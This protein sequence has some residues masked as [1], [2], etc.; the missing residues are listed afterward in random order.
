MV[1]RL[2]RLSGD[3][4]SSIKKWMKKGVS[5]GNSYDPTPDFVVREIEWLIAPGI[6]DAF[7]TETYRKMVGEYLEYRLLRWLFMSTTHSVFAIFEE[8]SILGTVC[9]VEEEYR[10]VDNKWECL[11]SKDVIHSHPVSWKGSY[12]FS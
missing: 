6:M 9:Y 7:G 12:Q 2:F 5:M 10:Y 1:E 3:N 11:H 8:H 4:L